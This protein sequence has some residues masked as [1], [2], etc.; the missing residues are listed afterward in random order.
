MHTRS[1]HVRCG[2]GAEIKQKGPYFQYPRKG[3]FKLQ[4]ALISEI[5]NI[6]FIQTKGQRSHEVSQVA[7]DVVEPACENGADG[8]RRRLPIRREEPR[9]SRAASRAHVTSYLSLRTLPRLHF[10]TLL[11]L[12]RSSAFGLHSF[13][14]FLFLIVADLVA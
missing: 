13:F 12:S 6:N 14:L 11:L 1:R 2:A 8:A 4:P 10:L 7:D 3:R 9:S 5:K